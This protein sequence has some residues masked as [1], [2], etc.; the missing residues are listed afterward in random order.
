MDEG[1]ER[2]VAN[3]ISVGEDVPNRG[4]HII[5]VTRPLRYKGFEL[6]RDAKDGYSPLLV[7]RDRH[8]KTLFGAYAPLQSIKQK[9]GTYLYRSGTTDALGSFNF[10]DGP[11]FSPVF[12]LQTVYHPDKIK[13]RVGEI[14]FQVWKARSHGQESSEELFN[15][16][17][18]FGERI[19][20]GDYMLSMD[21]VRYWT[22]MNLIHHPGLNFI[23]ASFWIALGGL[24]LNLVIKTVQRREEEN[25]TG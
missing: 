17:A 3:E 5:Y 15:G 4:K 25:L 16:K 22:S 8:G 20:A 21:E 6:Y 14:S 19:K 1:K 23:Y 12:R 2:G 24:I 10:P 11:G 9:D 13:K 18:T 7:L